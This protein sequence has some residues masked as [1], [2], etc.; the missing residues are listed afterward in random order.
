MLRSQ[1]QETIDFV[2]ERFDKMVSAVFVDYQGL[3]VASVTD[4]AKASA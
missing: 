1:K 4:S 2:K 3:D